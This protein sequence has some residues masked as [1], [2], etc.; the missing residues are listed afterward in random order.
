MTSTQK[1]V[2]TLLACVAL[3][4]GLTVSKVLNSGGEGGQAEQLDAGLV[5]LQQA[6]PL[7]QVELLDQNGEARRL[8]EL[9]GKWSLVFFGYTF[10]PDICPTTLADLRLIQSQL[11][12]A[13]REQLQVVLITVDPRRDTPQQL[14]EYLGYFDPQF[15]GLTGTPQ[16]IQAS[17]N[18][19]GVPYVPGDTS[20]ENYTVDHGGNLALIDP[21]G[22][23]RGFI[24]APLRSQK[25]VALL[26]A[27]VG[28]R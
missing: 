27:V 7:P 4:I 20:K 19:L 13:T 25:L 26:P 22:A 3:V 6:R 9:K 12:P 21:S 1:T 10:C 24:R 18:A 5:M 8:D 23:Q 14:K 2:F 15:I 17:A 16:A 28:Q 11:P